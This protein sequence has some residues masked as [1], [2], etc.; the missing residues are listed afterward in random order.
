MRNTFAFFAACAVAVSA[1]SAP[2]ET[3]LMDRGWYFAFGDASSPARDFGNATEYFTYFTK[4]AS[5][6]N[7]GPYSPKYDMAADSTRWR[8]VDLPHDWVVDLPYDCTASHSHGYKTVGW[9]WP[10]TSVGWYRKTFA[11]DSADIGRHIYVQFDGV[12][13]DSHVWLNGFYLGHEPSGYASGVYDL[14]DYLNYGG[15]NVLCVRADA[16]VEEG[17]FY[18][19][20]GIYR[21][22]WLV[23]TSSVHLEP[24]GVSAVADM[25][26][27]NLGVASLRVSA[28]LRNSSREKYAAARIRNTLRDA[29][30]HAVA[31]A[32][33]GNVRVPLKDTA[34]ASL[35]M[36]VA[37]PRLWSPSNPYLYRLT[38]EV[39]DA[40]GRVLDEIETPV[41]FRTIRFDADSGFILNGQRMP[42]RGVNMHQ[43][44][45]GVGCAIPDALQA[46][47]LRQLK[48]MGVNAYRSSHNP[49]TPAMLDACDSLGILVV[50]ENRLMGVND[51]HI[52][53]LERMIRRDRN[54]PS[55]IAWSVGNEEW[56]LE[57]N[58]QGERVVATMCDH[59]HRID[60][61]R[62]AT[63]ATSGG[64]ATILHA[65]V[66]GYNYV[67]QNPID[68]NRIR[69][70]R[71]C[72]FG[73]EETTGCGTR[74]VY[75]TDTLTGRM[76]A[77][78]RRHNGPDS[79][80]NCIERGMRFYAERPWLAGLFYW[81]G[82]D[83]RGEPNPMAFP[84]T[85]SEFGLLDY[86]GFPKDEA[87]YVKACWTD[88]P[89]L[90][91]LPHWN[92]DGCEG[93]SV[94][95]WVYTNCDEVELRQDGR[96]LGR[97][98]LVPM[99]HAEW[100][101]VYRPG[102]L[103]AIGWRNGRK[104]ADTRVR[105]AGVPARIEASSNRIELAADGADVAV[106]NVSLHD[107]KG[108]FTPTACLPV[109]VEVSGPARIL[110]GGNGDPAWQ[111]AERPSASDARNF[112]LPSFNGRA[113]ILV[114]TSFA[115]GDIVVRVSGAGDV[116]ELHLRAVS[117][118]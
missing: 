2:R 91:I 83:Y 77:H 105:T 106:V 90:H 49:M 32:E 31:S 60:P 47:R 96:S 62:P 34:V 89:V 15:D 108:N 118:N 101:T 11:V 36:D 52:R 67:V 87:Y 93:D 115:P 103:R 86:C 107:L 27:K 114:Q 102:E 26:E 95:V 113:Q 110:G 51:E 40:D 23:K 70:P 100:N 68:E 65:D 56:G 44:H 21:H 104:V 75:R 79:M 28:E 46:Y 55:I 37:S 38:T 111:S 61:T 57:W 16:S 35:A 73:S 117:G 97:R 66:A 54:H 69:F 20:A 50:E 59:V 81:T 116:K 14:T 39:L 7:A 19:G 6:H 88:E 94:S 78:N 41:G 63:A 10:E 9:Q 45:S 30:G 25:D 64:P 84:S 76:M 98:K 4:A 12:Y 24:F 53:L 33:S 22:V 17:W 99:T 8:R 82:F 92:L 42:L 43:D 112:T 13:R 71:R 85:G 80:L 29:G 74:G 58:V 72:A 109:T 1:M 48:K 3:E 5:V 18:E